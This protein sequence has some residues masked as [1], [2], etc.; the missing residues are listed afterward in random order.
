MESY[1][2]LKSFVI[3]FNKDH[4]DSAVTRQVSSVKP[5]AQLSYHATYYNI[6][7]IS[8]MPLTYTHY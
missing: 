3:P 6:Y 4:K 8:A 2:S 5:L 1:F 7:I